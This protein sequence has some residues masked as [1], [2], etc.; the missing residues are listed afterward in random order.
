MYLIHLYLLYWFFCDFDYNIYGM[1]ALHVILFLVIRIY[2]DYVFLLV[3][4][5]HLTHRCLG[6]TPGFV[7]WEPS[8]V[9]G[10]NLLW[11]HPRQVHYL[12]YYLSSR[13]TH[14]FKSIIIVKQFFYLVFLFDVWQKAYGF[15]TFRFHLTHYWW[16]PLWSIKP[17]FP[18]YRDIEKKFP[19]ESMLVIK[20]LSC[21]SVWN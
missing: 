15:W 4:C 20:S 19:S 14:L 12:L 5:S 8:V 7:P 2:A 18:K 9:L 13:D 21:T 16:H 17:I 1:L 3:W 6:L 11:L 10:S